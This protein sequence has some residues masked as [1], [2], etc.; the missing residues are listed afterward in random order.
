MEHR[1]TTPWLLVLAL[2]G[3]AGAGPTFAQTSFLDRPTLWTWDGGPHEPLPPR[4]ERPLVGDRPD[5]TEATTVV[6]RGV[7]QLE[8]GYTYSR[9]DGPDVTESHTYPELLLRIGMVAEWAE[10]RLIW[11]A[12]EEQEGA[13]SAPVVGSDD[14]TVGLKIA[15]TQQMDWLPETVFIGHLQLPTGSADFTADEVMPSGT[16]IYGW[17]LN[18]RWS[19]AGQTVLGRARDDATGEP[20]LEVAQSWTVGRS[21]TDNIGSYLEWFSIMPHGAD[22][23]P[24]ESYVDGGFTFL[25]LD[26]LQ[27]DVRAG[28]G[29]SDGADDYFIGTGL[30]IRH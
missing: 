21:V 28:V 30:I 12:A 11:S 7:S 15:L 24:V 17:E 19:T 23:N 8:M 3:G 10:L 22:A 4:D 27:W 20:Y 29:I 9:T 25:L 1:F 2:A 18:E 13:G 14:F 5:F 26:D 16:Y 6:G